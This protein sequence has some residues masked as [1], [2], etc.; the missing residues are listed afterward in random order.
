MLP[1]RERIPLP[2]RAITQMLL[3]IHGAAGESEVRQ[4]LTIMEEADHDAAQFVRQVANQMREVG[5]L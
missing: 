2:M 4:M 3:Y 1:A 5:A